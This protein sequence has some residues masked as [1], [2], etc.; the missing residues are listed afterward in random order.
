MSLSRAPG[1]GLT[2]SSDLAFTQEALTA[3]AAKV[4]AKRKDKPDA[5]TFARFLEQFRADAFL[6]DFLSLTVDDAASLA[7]D[8]WDFNKANETLTNRVIRTRRATGAEGRALKLDVAEIAG[9]DMAVRKPRSRFAPRFIRLYRVRR[10]NGRPSRFICR[11]STMPC[12]RMFGEYSK[13]PS[14]T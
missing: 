1:G 14:P 5:E 3:A 11:R 13:R 12:V 8:L 2:Q 4:L 6:E 7:I 10:A 9:P